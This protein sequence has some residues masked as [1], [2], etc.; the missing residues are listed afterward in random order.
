MDETKQ[1]IISLFKKN[2]GDIST[3]ELLLEVYPES[4]N[5]LSK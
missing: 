4:K 5:L 2:G 1:K 3:N